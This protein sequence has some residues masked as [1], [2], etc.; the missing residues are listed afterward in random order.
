MDVPDIFTRSRGVAVLFF[1]ALVLITKWWM[2]LIAIIGM[3]ILIRSIED[4]RKGFDM[5]VFKKNE[6]IFIVLYIVLFI[7]AHVSLHFLYH[8]P[9]IAKDIILAFI[10]PLAVWVIIHRIFWHYFCKKSRR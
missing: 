10:V 9:V 2:P 7:I 4:A 5:Y 3:I 8:E 6:I 1:L